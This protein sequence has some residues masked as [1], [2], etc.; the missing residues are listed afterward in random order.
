MS[1]ALVSDKDRVRSNGAKVSQSGGTALCLFGILRFYA[2][3]QRAVSPHAGYGVTSFVC[4]LL[5]GI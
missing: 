3:V 1:R 4:D 2:V 5:E